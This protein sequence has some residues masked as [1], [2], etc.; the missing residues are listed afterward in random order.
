MSQLTKH[1]GRIPACPAGIVAPYLFTKVE[2]GELKQTSYLNQSFV[3]DAAAIFIVT[4]VRPMAG[5][6]SNVTTADVAT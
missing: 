3:T 2:L 1:D 4:V 5:V 6:T